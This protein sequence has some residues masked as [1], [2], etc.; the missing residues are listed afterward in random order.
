MSAIPG[1]LDQLVQV[2]ILAG[3]HRN[4]LALIELVQPVNPGG[5]GWWFRP[6]GG[7]APGD[8]HRAPAA[9]VVAAHHDLVADGVAARIFV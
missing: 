5:P 6:P 2:R 7:A 3:A 9:T 1:R 4:P 8:S